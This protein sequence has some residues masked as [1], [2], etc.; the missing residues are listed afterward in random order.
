MAFQSKT[1]SI[2]LLLFEI[3]QNLKSLLKIDR[4]QPLVIV[5]VY[6]ELVYY[7]AY[8]I[9]TFSF[10]SSYAIKNWSSGDKSNLDSLNDKSTHF[11][12]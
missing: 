12:N 2:P 9:V 6:Y 1:Y 5:I 10:L 11:I 3:T 7:L 8:K 4:E